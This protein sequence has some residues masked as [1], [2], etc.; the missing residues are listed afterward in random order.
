MCRV[1]FRAEGVYLSLPYIELLEEPC[2]PLKETKDYPLISTVPQSVE[3]QTVVG[4]LS[5][6]SKATL[7]VTEKTLVLIFGDLRIR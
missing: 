4:E 2:Y 5:E 7:E 1:R 3:K 6:Q